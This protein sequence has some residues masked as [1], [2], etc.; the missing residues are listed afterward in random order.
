MRLILSAQGQ[1]QV[2]VSLSVSMNDVNAGLA[3]CL[4]E[5]VKAA[6]GHSLLQ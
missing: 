6:C 4:N 3:F 1:F 5:L 2:H